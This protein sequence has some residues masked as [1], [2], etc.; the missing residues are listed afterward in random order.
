MSATAAGH[1][2]SWS[3]NPSLTSVLH[4]SKSI[5]TVRL[6]HCLQAPHLHTTSQ[7]RDMLPDPTH[8]K[9]SHQLNLGHGS[10]WQSLITNQTT[11]THFNLVFAVCNGT[12]LYGM[13]HRTVYIRSS[14]SILRRAQS[15][16]FS[17][18]CIPRYTILVA[19]YGGYLSRGHKC[20]VYTTL[21]ELV[22]YSVDTRQCDSD[23]GLLYQ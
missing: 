14:W 22:V 12:Q 5:G 20:G 16:W 15:H 4:R 6:D 13:I 19:Q 2:A 17:C 1:L 11:R 8:A 21:F 10:H 23:S 9:V 7:T 18:N 3:I